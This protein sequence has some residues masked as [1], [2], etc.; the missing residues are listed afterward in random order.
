MKTTLNFIEFHVQFDMKN[1]II[2]SA[3]MVVHSG[4]M[5]AQY[6]LQ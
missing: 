1:G 2:Y 4:D 5:C 3:F 6:K